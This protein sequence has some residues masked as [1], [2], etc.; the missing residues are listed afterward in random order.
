MQ[1]GPYLEHAPSGGPRVDLGAFFV[2]QLGEA[3]LHKSALLAGRPRLPPEYMQIY[4]FKGFGELSSLKFSAG[5]LRGSRND[6][7]PTIVQVYVPPVRVHDISRL[8]GPRSSLW[9]QR[10]SRWPYV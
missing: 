1:V 2:R 7:S 5:A 4:E 10:L 3:A 9:P 8:P 6:L